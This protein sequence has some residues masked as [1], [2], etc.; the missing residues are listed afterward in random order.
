MPSRLLPSADPSSRDRLSFGLEFE[1]LLCHSHSAPIADPIEHVKAILRRIPVK[2]QDEP[3]PHDLADPFPTL[4]L[5]PHDG[6]AVVA[7]QTVEDDEL[8][9]PRG[10]ACH[11]QGVEITTP[12]LWDGPEALEHVGAVLREL[13]RHLRMRVNITSGLHCHVGAGSEKFVTNDGSLRIRPRSFSPAVLRN[14]AALLW[15]A[16]GFL[17]HAHPPERGLSKHTATIRA[18]SKLSR[19]HLVT[20]TE[21]KPLPNSSKSPP[22]RR[23]HS[24][25]KTFPARRPSTIDSSAAA[26]FHTL[27]DNRALRPAPAGSVRTESAMLGARQIMACR[28]TTDVA[29]LLSEEGVLWAHRLNY[30]FAAY[31]RDDDTAGCVKSKTAH[32]SSSSTRTV[33]FREAAGS[34]CPV[35]VPA[36]ADICLGIFRF[37]ATE[38]EETV[39]AVVERLEAAEEE[40]RRGGPGGGGGGGGGYDMVSFLEDIGV[41]GSAAVLERRLSRDPLA[42]W[43]PCRIGAGGDDGK[44]FF[45]GGGGE[46]GEEGCL[47]GAV[48]PAVEDSGAKGEGVAGMVCC[49]VVEDRKEMEHGHHAET[50]GRWLDE[51]SA[52][53]LAAFDRGRGAGWPFW[54]SS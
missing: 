47:V 5:F 39:W 34:V 15:A 42:A 24:S 38:T 16:D 11:N 30:N 3:V 50:A 36:W 2:L 28:T 26:R 44:P 17:C 9:P 14:A 48:V 25:R 33:E 37:A 19:G 13:Q 54:V 35:W 53:F 32:S 41:S 45:V 43:Y 20:D 22:P 10:F 6:W 40:A 29:R 12:A 51:I 46:E 49:A 31:T 1:F 52:R 23:R 21:S 4:Q 18:W 27:A 7:D 8:A